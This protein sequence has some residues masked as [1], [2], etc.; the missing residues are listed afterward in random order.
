M[1]VESW[2]D[3]LLGVISTLVFVLLVNF[4][5]KT[6]QRYTKEI[7]AATKP[8]LVIQK[9]EKTPK[10]IV[11]AAE[12]ARIKRLF[13]LGG[14]ALLGLAILYSLFPHFFENVVAIFGL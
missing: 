10:E 7:E 13:M 4:L 11:D 3:F 8:Q 6:Y 12:I 1:L 5:T 9:T 14:T 2:Y